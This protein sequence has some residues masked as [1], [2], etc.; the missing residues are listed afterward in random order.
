MDDHT[1]YLQA[2]IEQILI[3]NSISNPATFNDTSSPQYQALNWMAN[4]GDGA[5]IIQSESI[6]GATPYII[7]RYILAV[8]YYST[9]GV[10]W[11]KQYD[12]LTNTNECEW[13]VGANNGFNVIDCNND[14]FVT[15]INL[16]Q[17]QL[18]GVIPT[19][20]VHLTNCTAL[21]F[22]TNRLSGEVPVEI[23]QMKLDYLNLGYNQ[24]SGT[25]M[26]EY[27]NLVN[28]SK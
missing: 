25:V 10:G 23:T 24:L 16:W 14:G 26:P 20:L 5:D 18:M 11:N 21:D 28:V 13:G 19:E 12:F 1:N 22:L 3:Q 4:S 27:G 8:L 17:N 6:Q 15:L 2:T 7:Q 9:T